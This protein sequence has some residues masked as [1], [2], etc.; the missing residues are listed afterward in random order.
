M[1]Q[2]FVE[3]IDIREHPIKKA[4]QKIQIE[5]I[6]ALTYIIEKTISEAMLHQEEEKQFTVERLHV[7]Q[8]H[9]IS[10]T[11]VGVTDE[12]NGARSLTAFSKPWRGKYRFM[13]L[14]D[15]ALILFDDVLVSAAMIIIQEHWPDRRKVDVEQVTALL[16]NN[17]DVE[18][19][20]LPASPLV[21]QYRS[22]KAF[23]SRSVR[24][25]IVTANTSAGKSTLINA[26]IGK[27]IARTSQEA[28]TGNVCYLFNK[29]YEDKKIHLLTQGLNLDA[30]A[31]DLDGY[32]WNGNIY[33]SSYFAGLVSEVP[34][35]C[36]IDTPGVD[37]AL[38]KEHS[39][40]A[41]NALL[42]DDYD[43]IIYVVSPTRLG[44]DAE[45]KHL[46]WVAQN[47]QKE[48]LL[49]VLNRVDDYREFSDSVEESVRDFKED[50]LKLGFVDPVICPISAYFSYLLKMKMTGQALSEDEKDEYAVYAKKFKRSVYDLSHYYEGVQIFP[51]D[52]EEIV[53]SKRVG[54]Y[55]LER[56]IYGGRL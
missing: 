33:I 16:Q 47:L 19:K 52:S 36:I 37:A 44:T 51:T 14:C 2:L 8:N 1:N 49:F 28:C 17:R 10:G 22:N 40:R 39:R 29:P 11:C 15:V 54:L 50:L 25:I 30:T 18:K 56:I 55:G 27:P 13:L 6:T 7:Y 12:K 23:C 46:Q 5:Y 26:L 48:K 45:K 34:R 9:L 21:K 3:A 43:T 24:R 4:K 38:Y 20:Y 42:N 53:L 32:D 41:Y 31:E 35:L